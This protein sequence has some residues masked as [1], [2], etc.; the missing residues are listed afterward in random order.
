MR[1]SWMI[2][3]REWKERVSSRSFIMMSIVGPLIVLGLVY[4]MFALGG[5]SK[6]HWN[7][8][9]ADPAGIMNNKIMAQED[10]SVTYSFADGYIEIDEFRDGKKYQ[11]F[12]ALLEVNEKVLSNK[13]GFLFY[14]DKP[15]IRMQTRVQYQFERRLEEVVVKELTTMSLTKFRSVKQPINVTFA[16]VND[17][18]G[19][20][21]DLSGWAGFFFGTLIFLFIFLFGMTV[22]RS[23][24]REK[25]NRI[26]EVLLA[27]VSPLQLMRGKI[28]GIG[29]SAFLQF[30][31]WIAIIGGGLYFMRETIFP[32]VMDASNINIEQLTLDANDASYQ[33]SYYA[34]R[35]YNEFVNLV[36]ERVQFVNT[37]GFFMLFFVGGYL[38]YS[39]IFAA[40]GATMGSESDGQQFV[41]PIVIILCLSLYAGY[42]VMNNPETQLSTFLHYFPFT[43]PVVV[44]VKLYQGYEIGHAYE[45]YIAFF[46][47][48]VSAFIALAIAARLYKNGILQFGHRLRIK[49]LFK[50]LKS[51]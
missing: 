25:N 47:L 5:E 45:I 28:I 16:D 1:K 43:A 38:F 11:E 37:L 19:K 50:W 36:Y 22:L 27:S 2:A 46:S 31:I 49:H 44:M 14:R 4:V 26:V 39:A 18:E 6:Q 48:I 41:I 13:T 10:R 7:V 33:E 29:M 42:Y 23:I 12:D 21:N 24:S 20:A 9:I 35:E 3:V 8:L 15:S 34:A 40:I 30:V 32:D 17:P 51:A